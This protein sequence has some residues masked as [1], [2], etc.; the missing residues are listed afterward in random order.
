M[1]LAQNT[2]KWL[3]IYILL[4]I[5]YRIQRHSTMYFS[6]F[7]KKTLHVQS[8]ICSRCAAHLKDMRQHKI[9]K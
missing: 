5:R 2:H 3:R 4:R 8:A 7:K 1:Q 9:V 6:S